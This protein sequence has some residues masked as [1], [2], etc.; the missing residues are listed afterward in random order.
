LG[1]KAHESGV[2]C[3]KFGRYGGDLFGTKNPAP[4]TDP[5][6]N[7]K[8]E[9]PDFSMKAFTSRVFHTLM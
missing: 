5:A 9:T 7:S 1:R 2:N 3:E 8:Q 4:G 6:I